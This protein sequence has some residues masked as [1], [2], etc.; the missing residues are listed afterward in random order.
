MNNE[1]FKIIVDK[2][3][4]QS[5]LKL[6]K[7]NCNFSTSKDFESIPVC[8]MRYR[9]IKIKVLCLFKCIFLLILAIFC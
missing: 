8:S 7:Y 4:S 5:F 3:N 1:I 9:L 6:N 2:K